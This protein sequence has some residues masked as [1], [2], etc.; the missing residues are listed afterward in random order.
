MKRGERAEDG[1]GVDT[2]D[3]GKGGTVRM[4]GK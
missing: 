3:E 4:V 1:E 2:D